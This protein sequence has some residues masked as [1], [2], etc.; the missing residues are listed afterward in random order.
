MGTHL[1][2]RLGFWLLT[3]MLTV[4]MKSAAA[5]RPR[6]FNVR[7]RGLARVDQ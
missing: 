4:L 7:C 5:W 1:G 2:R 6:R 3:M